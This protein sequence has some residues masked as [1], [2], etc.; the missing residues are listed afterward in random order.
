MRWTPPLQRYRNVLITDKDGPGA[1]YILAFAERPLL[2]INGHWWACLECPLS[3]VKR[4]KSGNKRTL[5][6]ACTVSGVK[7]TSYRPIDWLDRQLGRTATANRFA[8]IDAAWPRNAA[9]GFALADRWHP[10]KKHPRTPTGHCGARRRRGREWRSN[11]ISTASFVSGDY[12][13]A[14][15]VPLGGAAGRRRADRSHSCRP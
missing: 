14:M 5:V 4:T 9:R 3:G 10:P 6:I 8:S 7:R 2:A 15:G 13:E 1:S 12:W 11:Q